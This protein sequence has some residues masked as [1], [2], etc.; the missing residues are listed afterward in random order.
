MEP[1]AGS[2]PISVFIKQ[3]KKTL[4][5]GLKFPHHTAKFSPL[6]KI[7]QIVKSAKTASTEV[8][9]AKDGFPLLSAHAKTRISGID[10]S[11]EFNS[12]YKCSNAFKFIV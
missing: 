4:F 10:N 6:T 3:V 9:D 5:C 11:I 8:H 7:E 1:N 12:G 2:Q